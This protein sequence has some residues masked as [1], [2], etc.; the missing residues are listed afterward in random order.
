MSDYIRWYGPLVVI[1]LGV[2]SW[3]VTLGCVLSLAYTLYVYI[4]VK[5]NFLC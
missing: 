2:M 3:D 4:Y 5:M 1:I